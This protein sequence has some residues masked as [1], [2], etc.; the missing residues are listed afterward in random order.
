MLGREEVIP[1]HVKVDTFRFGSLR[2]RSGQVAQRTAAGEAG[3]VNCI[4]VFCE[5]V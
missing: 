2:R 5:M 4:T 3:E 1:F